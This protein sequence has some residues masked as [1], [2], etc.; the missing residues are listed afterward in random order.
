M[1]LW[2]Q[3][4][5]WCQTRTAFILCL[6]AYTRC[7]TPDASGTGNDTAPAFVQLGVM[8]ADVV[9]YIPQS[10]EGLAAERTWPV[11]ALDVPDAMHD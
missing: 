11:L 1:C 7:Y 4:V 3:S 2:L 8:G 5:R 9:P 10:K 6:A